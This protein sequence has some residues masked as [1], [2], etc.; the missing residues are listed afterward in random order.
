MPPSTRKV[1]AVM[2]DHVVAGQEGDR[3]RDLLGLGEPAHRHV[4]RPGRWAR[5][6][7]GRRTVPAA[8]AC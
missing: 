3:G 4:D 6:G 7:D 1:D 8:A 2:K 5:S